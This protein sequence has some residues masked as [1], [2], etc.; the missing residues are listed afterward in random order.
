MTTRFKYLFSL[1]QQTLKFFNDVLFFYTPHEFRLFL[2]MLAVIPCLI[3]LQSHV[4]GLNQQSFHVWFLNN[5]MFQAETA[6]HSMSDLS[7]IPCFRLKLAV[8]P[9]LI[10]GQSPVSGWHQ[11]HSSGQASAPHRHPVSAQAAPPAH[12]ARTLHRGGAQ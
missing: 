1:A 3:Y 11:Q 8:T 7:T 4:S 2:R 5:P 9:C 12:S 10:Y 6:S